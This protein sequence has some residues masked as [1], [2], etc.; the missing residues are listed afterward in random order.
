M[1]NW[2]GLGRNSLNLIQ[3]QAW[4][5]SRGTKENNDWLQSVAGVTVEIRTEHLPNTGLQCYR[6]SNLLS[7][8]KISENIDKSHH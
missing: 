8:T 2:K 7:V 5:L 3:A 4:D 6:Y 1:M